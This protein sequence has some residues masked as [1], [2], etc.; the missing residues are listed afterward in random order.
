MAVTFMA[1][2]GAACSGSVATSSPTPV[3]PVPTAPA[4]AATASP[5]PEARAPAETSEAVSSSPAD[6]GEPLSS[7]FR[8]L[9]PS[10][11]K[12]VNP[13]SFFQGLPQDTI[14]PI[15]FPFVTTAE[16]VS[17]DSGE[18]VIGVSIGD[19]SRAYPIR[20]LRF[21]EMVNDKL[22]GIPILV[23]W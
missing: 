14:E 11:P 19:E 22:G 23:T 3:T 12:L 4:P 20:T 15:Y 10:G 16:E 2:V 6:A 7:I 21:R 1:A 9:N 13:G 17:I 5:Q 8:E 18:L